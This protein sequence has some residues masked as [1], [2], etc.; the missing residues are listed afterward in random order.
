MNFKYKIAVEGD[1]LVVMRIA[2]DGVHSYYFTS[3]PDAPYGDVQEMYNLLSGAG[4][5]MEVEE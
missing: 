5:D 2:D 1:V 3:S 4:L